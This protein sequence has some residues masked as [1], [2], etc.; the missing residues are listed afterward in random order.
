MAL[1]DFGA[2]HTGK[3]NFDPNA[4]SISK[5]ER[6][7]EA[8]PV[9]RPG[10]R[11]GREPGGEM[12]EPRG[13]AVA[14]GAGGRW[15]GAHPLPPW[16]FRPARKGMGGEEGGELPGRVG[17][18][19]SVSPRGRAEQLQ[20]AGERAVGR[21]LRWERALRGAAAGVR[22]ARLPPRR[23][24]GAHAAPAGDSAPREQPSPGTGT[25]CWLAALL[26]PLV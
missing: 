14:S 20:S 13:A 26:Y 12:C 24:R 9:G 23:G 21:A 25:C 10:G 4:A 1:L 2:I 15:R 5:T 6:V 17:L 18:R 22:G 8:R 3:V 7:E 16:P 11:Q 19:R